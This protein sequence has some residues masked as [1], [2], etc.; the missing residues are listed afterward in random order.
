[1]NDHALAV[2]IGDLEMASSEQRM[3][4]EYS[5]ITMMRRISSL[6][7]QSAAELFWTEYD[8]NCLGRLGNGCARQIRPSQRLDVEK[9]QSCGAQCKVPAWSLR[10]RNK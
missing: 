9:A 2:D 5:V 7:N 8:G 3:P 10:S 1:M 6:L 4:V